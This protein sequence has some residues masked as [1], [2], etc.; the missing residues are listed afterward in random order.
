MT[1]R[2]STIFAS[3]VLASGL[4][5]SGSAHA[6]ADDGEAAFRDLYRELV[7][8]NTTRSVGG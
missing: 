2:L 6:A 5:L 1:Y 4:L 7:E 8:I 3:L